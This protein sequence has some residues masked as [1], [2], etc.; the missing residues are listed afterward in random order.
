MISIAQICALRFSV[1]LFLYSS[2]LL[3]CRSQNLLTKPQMVTSLFFLV[4]RES[5]L[6]EK[7]LP[8]NFLCAEGTFGLSDLRTR[9]D[10]FRVVRFDT[11]GVGRFDSMRGWQIWR[12]REWGELEEG[13]M[14]EGQNELHIGTGIWGWAKR[15]PHFHPYIY[16]FIVRYKL[17]LISRKHFLGFK[18][19]FHELVDG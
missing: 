19:Q 13:E 14:R 7:N 6:E 2:I 8:E 11:W 17:I 5:D 1:N 18:T 9:F 10:S 15:V 4:S 12:T 3:N 16:Y